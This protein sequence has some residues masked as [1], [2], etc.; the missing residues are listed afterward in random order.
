MEV[1]IPQDEKRRIPPLIL[2]YTTTL[3]LTKGMENKI[4]HV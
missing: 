4:V 2:K 3:T 1:N